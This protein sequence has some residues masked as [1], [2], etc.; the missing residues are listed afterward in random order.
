MRSMARYLQEQRP[1]IGDL[2]CTR[3]ATGVRFV[4]TGGE[5]AALGALFTSV[6]H[7]RAHSESRPLSS[8]VSH[9]SPSRVVPT[10]MRRRGGWRAPGDARNEQGAFEGFTQGVES[11][12]M[13][14]LNRARS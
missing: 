4:T 7:G 9:R 5:A 8:R 10:T 6:R 2:R 12:R 3:N 1:F 14:M 13:V 11:R